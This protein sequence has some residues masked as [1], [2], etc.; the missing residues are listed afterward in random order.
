MAARHHAVHALSAAAKGQE[1]W[2]D[3]APD[4]PCSH[5]SGEDDDDHHGIGSVGI[6]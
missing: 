1:S 4:S 5:T 6:E 2:V 3:I